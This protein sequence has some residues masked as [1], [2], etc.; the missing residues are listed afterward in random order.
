MNLRMPPLFTIAA[1]A[2]IP[3]T[4]VAADT[5]ASAELT[6]HADQSGPTINRNIYGQFAE[7]LGH[8][9]YGG[10]WVEENSSIPNTHGFRND[11]LGALKNLHIP[12]LRWPG[13]CFADT[14]H[15]KDGIGPREKRPSIINSNWGGVVENNHF[16]T[17]EFLD[18]CEMIGTEPYI[19]GNLGS[20]TVQ[21]MAE[22]VEY[23]TSDADSPMANLRRANGREKAWKVPY[24]AVGNESWGCG[25]NMRPEYYSDE[26]RRYNTFLKDY[27]PTKLF[28]IA[29]GPNEDNYQWTDTL[30]K[31]DAKEH[32]NG[33]SLHYYTI[34]T[35]RWKGK[36]SATKF[37]EDQYFSTL[38]NAFKMDEL[39]KQH[40]LIM[41]HYDPQKKVGLVVD[42]WGIWTDEE[43]GTNPAFLFQQN[44][45]RDAL[46]AAVH[47]H[48]FQAHADR[49]VMA[50]IA[51]M[52]NVLQ[53]MILTNDHGMV[54]TPTY[55][56]FE[57]FTV[58]Q[59]ATSLSLDVKSPEYKFG[60]QTLPAVTGSASRDKSGKVHLSLLNLDP[61]REITVDCAVDGVNAT[62]VTGR[63]LTASSM[64][65]HNTFEDPHHVEPKAFNGASVTQ[66]KL[67]VKLPP[68]SVVVL[69]L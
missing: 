51:Q 69:T 16:G 57:M 50:N 25:G 28:R 55:H 44:S 42:E 59:D 23:M 1:L 31:L 11:V 12:V 13:G 53:A 5:E 36:G 22:W 60:N 52:V 58:H 39:I 9:I 19:T 2:L 63:I 68:L 47:F 54:L 46:V 40:S 29:V 6:L 33:L 43:P 30:M 49:V 41:D 27:G 37:G 21:E 7:H 17:N 4:L 35:G 38:H 64:T 8:G 24:F 56:V 62:N 66:G 14:Y 65:D 32:M 15:W 3:V 18:L 34:P 48:I 67:T 20:G 26:Y 61:H 10:I 45:M